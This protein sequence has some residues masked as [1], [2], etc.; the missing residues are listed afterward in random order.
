MEKSGGFF[1]EATKGN[2]T[3]SGYFQEVVTVLKWMHIYSSVLYF[4]D[5][6]SSSLA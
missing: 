3:Y 6:T 5:V 2:G 4:S 1:K